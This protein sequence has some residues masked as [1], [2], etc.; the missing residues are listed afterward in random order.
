MKTWHP[1]ALL[2]ALST[3]AVHAQQPTLLDHFWMRG[4][5]QVPISRGMID[6]ANNTLYLA[7]SNSLQ[8]W[9]PTSTANGAVL[10]LGEG[11][12][13]LTGS[14]TGGFVWASV[15]DGAGGW[16]IGGRFS[17]VNGVTRQGLARLHA[18]GAL[19]ESWNPGGVTGGSFPTVFAL[20]VHEGIL[21]IGGEF[22]SAGGAARY[23]LA[24]FD[25]AAGEL[26]SW[27]QGF[28]T[29]DGQVRAI[30]VTDDAVHVGGEFSS[31]GG[32]ARNNIATLSRQTGAALSTWTTTA[33]AT[34]MG[35]CAADD[36]LYLVGEFTQVNGQGRS[37]IARLTGADGALSDW[38]PGANSVVNC[39]AV[40][41]DTVFVGG[42]F[43]TAGGASHQ[44]L[45]ALSR[46]TNTN[47]ALSWNAPLTGWRVNTLQVTGSL[48]YAGGQFTDAGVTPVPRAGVAA[49]DRSTGAVTPWNPG[50][51]AQ[52][53]YT[54]AYDGQAIYAGGSFAAIGVRV[55]PGVAAFDLTT[56]KPST[57]AAAVNSGAANHVYALALKG[58]T[59]FVAGVFSGVNGV[60]RQNV[61]SVHRITGE[62]FPWEVITNGVVYD[63]EVIGNRLILGGAF[64]SVNGVNRSGLAAVNIATAAVVPSWQA[65]CAG[66]L[67]QIDEIQLSNGR[68]FISG[69][70]DELA[71]QPRVALAVIDANTAALDAWQPYFTP[72][73]TARMITD[74]TRVIT[75][76]TGGNVVAMSAVDGSLL[77]DW[78]CNCYATSPYE[79]SG[80]VLYL[81]ATVD[82]GLTALDL[83]TGT[84]L[85]WTVEMDPSMDLH[86]AGDHLVAIGSFE[87]ADGIPRRGFAVFEVPSSFEDINTAVPQ[88]AGVQPG[89]YPN[90]V[91]AQLT[92]TTTQAREP[93]EVL[94]TKGRLVLSMVLQGTGPHA[95]DVSALENGTYILR[96]PWTTGDQGDLIV[97]QH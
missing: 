9:P 25:I 46:T 45:A 53:V 14:P 89:A 77:P 94:D 83:S 38:A 8:Y 61:A 54:L 17:A 72:S 28:S 4:V 32:V 36:E 79:V 47:N 96:R 1:L 52:P 90:P 95:V 35:L 30:A 64:T 21:Y 49:F 24:A 3:G 16:F 69:W 41:G 86:R 70:F 88:Q 15:P 12:P 40:A 20:A 23:R 51:S 43:S 29:N 66:G 67:A 91:S 59:V 73:G 75:R 48:V 87:E 55:R 19:D 58:D 80:D 68:L 81:R 27:N 39:V 7:G 82:L 37:R 13:Q 65:D 42:D 34:V 22:T 71:G 10:D 33:N 18:N 26:T 85:G 84:P 78:N 11:W 5:T 57:W 60:P 2:I 6:A 97:I 92:I 63:M 31:M 44:R 50:T 93:I 74:G 62:V 76:S 56:G